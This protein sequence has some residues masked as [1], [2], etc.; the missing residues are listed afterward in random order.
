[1]GKKERKVAVVSQARLNSKR[2]PKKMVRDFA[3][4]NLF[5][6]LLS[7]LEKSNLIPKED[8][9]ISVGMEKPIMDVVY[10]FDFNVFFRSDESCNST[11]SSIPDSLKLLYEWDQY[12]MD[13]GYTH[14]I[15]VSA[16]NPLLK[17]ETINSFY[18]K[19]NNLGRNGMFSVTEKKNYYWDEFGEPITDWKG[20]KLMNTRK[21][22]KVLE[23]AHCLYGSRLDYIQRELWMD[24]NYPPR[25]DMF[26][27][28]DLEATDI[29]T[30]EDFEVAEV[31][32]KNLYEKA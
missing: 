31:L 6:I 7:K 16:C 12:L 30:L 10:E 5:R 13:K 23:G 17:I 20:M 9:F 24:E 8:I 11:N 14:V 28:S 25:P 4:T 15:L 29:D 1:M 2:V 32:Y 27:V 26:I 18:T 3:G 22:D 21:V 19:F